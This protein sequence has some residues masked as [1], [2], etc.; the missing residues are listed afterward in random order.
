MACLWLLL[1]LC[2]RYVQVVLCWHDADKD[3]HAQLH[4]NGAV[5]CGVQ[6]CA[7]VWQMRLARARNRR[8][9]DRLVACRTCVAGVFCLLYACENRLP[10]FRSVAFPRARHQASALDSQRVDVGDGAEF[11]IAVHVVYLLC[12]YRAS[13]RGVA[14][15]S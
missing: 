4:C 11:R 10:T 3:S 2:R 9:G 14:C 5:E 6:L 12:L 13:W 8:R 15:H 7:R 1:C